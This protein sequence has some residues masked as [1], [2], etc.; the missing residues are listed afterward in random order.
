MTSA[1]PNRRQVLTTLG[2]A[3]IGAATAASWVD[4]LGAFAREQAHAGAAQAA[5]TAV[6]WKP[7][8]LSTH[9]NDTV[10]VLTELIIPE[11]DTPGA[12]ATF[13][14]RFVDGVLA[15]ARTEQRDAFVRGLT[16]MDERSRAL[17]GQDFIDARPADQIALLTSLS[18]ANNPDREAQ[19]GI[20]FFQAI[21]SMTIAGYYTT[22][23]G[24]R[25]ELG[26]SGQLFQRVSQGCD[27]P[28]HQG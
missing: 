18:A 28:E 20:E 2:T 17:F 22:E 27:H 13:V 1:H 24:M 23:I 11:T 9:Q 16:W 7:A 12:K 10:I 19:T 15:D 25:R 4:S 21:K 6:D 26:D 14:N 3:A 8:V 5:A